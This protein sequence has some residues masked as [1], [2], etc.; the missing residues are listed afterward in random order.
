[1]QLSKRFLSKSKM[2]RLF[3]LIILT[4][5]V[6]KSFAQQQ[7][8]LAIGLYYAAK[9][10]QPNPIYATATSGTRSESELTNTIGF[11]INQFYGQR[12]FIKTG[13]NYSFR[14]VKFND[15]SHLKSSRDSFGNPFLEVVGYMD[16]K[17]KYRFL[18]VPLLGNFLLLKRNK[19]TNILLSFGL[20]VDYILK[21]EA[22]ANSS[23][24]GL[25]YLKMKGSDFE[26]PWRPSIH[27]GIGVSHYLSNNFM[28]LIKPYY[29]NYFLEN[30][31]AEFKGDIN[32]F[33]IS[34]EI[35]YCFD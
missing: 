17:E 20:E 3:F 8:R 14:N 7:N 27:L 34:M 9:L 1:M 16:I 32:N 12:F 30:P 23:F 25:H 35:L 18:N 13:L 28:A 26:N 19:A 11:S 6:H 5:L 31:A 4:I 2:A 24:D 22:F 29:L 10:S 33:G 21:H 15:I